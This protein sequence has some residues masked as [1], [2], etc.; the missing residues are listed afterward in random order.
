[1]FFFAALFAVTS[2]RARS[3]ATLAAASLIALAASACS[4]DERVDEP[5]PEVAWPT[6]SCDPLV[7]SYCGFPFP[8]NV[9]TTP[10][11]TT[12][13][14]LRVVIG[15][16]TLPQPDNGTA[17]SLDGLPTSD[18]FSSGG[19]ILAEMPGAVDVGFISPFEPERSLEPDSLT[20]VIDADTLER[21]PHFSELDKSQPAIP[22]RALLIR[23]V[24]RLEDGRRYIVAIRGVRNAAGV[25][26]P[27]PA[28]A[29]LRDRRPFDEDPS[30]DRR[31]GLYADIFGRLEQAGVSRDSL[32]LAWDFTTASRG[33]N[34]GFML[35]MRDEAL[36]AA[37]DD[38]PPYTITKV[39]TEVDDDIL[40]RIEGTFEA[41][42][43]LDNPGPGGRLVFGADGLPEVNAGQPTVDVP[44]LVLIP[45][46]AA[47]APAA[48]LQ[49]G[50]G[51]LGSLGQLEAGNFR[52]LVNDK[53]Y[54]IFGLTLNGMGDDDG[55]WISEQLVAGRIDTLTAM[56]DRQHQGM[57]QYLLAMRMMKNGF[58]ND[59]TYGSYVDASQRYYH[60]ISQGGIFGGTYMA[61]TTDVER[62]VLGVA[63]MSYN[64]LLKRSVDFGP[65]FALMTL[66]FPEPRDQQLLLG[67]VQMF[68]DR[69]EPNGYV[70][71]I[72]DPL[73]G[74]PAHSVLIR[75]AIG[76][77]QVTT[78]GG[79]VMARAAGAVHIDTQQRPV[80]GLDTVDG[81]ASGSSYVEYGFGLPAEPAC[82]VPMTACDDPHGEIRHLD[83]ANDQLDRFLR[84]GETQNFCGGGD[85]SFPDLGGC[86]ASAET[87]FCP[88]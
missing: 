77:H 45:R 26:P 74:T 13:T 38:G 47:T 80:F 32:Q 23:P 8:S 58:A 3:A 75:T 73:P 36:A 2:G 70:P 64:L 28:F 81:A 43:Y 31:R 10:D 67:L 85:C 27:S 7:P 25:I 71:Y 84:T 53:G 62:G 33:N 30:V 44:F 63:G 40:F 9:F 15:D 79:Q 61:L 29:A 4:D 76:D 19:A 83:E 39:D 51:L 6:L 48:L 17:V 41:P 35:H 60:G 66:T 55:A 69:T 12:D 21:V 57:L 87:P 16:G 82:N 54:V 88:P 5:P 59:P 65:F 78:I 18:G 37:G 46:A 22:E 72:S 42:L 11:D 34:T 20:V 49:Y 14:G 56:F 1:M 52:R 68:W 50:H 86:D 24:T